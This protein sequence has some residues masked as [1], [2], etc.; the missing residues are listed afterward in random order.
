MMHGGWRREFGRRIISVAFLLYGCLRMLGFLLSSSMSYESLRVFWGFFSTRMHYLELFDF[1]LHSMIG[2][3]MVIWLLEAER[4][5]LSDAEE[6]VRQSQ[7]LEALG[8]LAGGI[9]HDFNNILT[10]ILGYSDLLMAR[11]GADDGAKD[12]QEIH[13]A[14]KR[15]SSLTNQL[16]AFS[17]KQVLALEVLDMNEVISGMDEMLRRLI[18]ESI[19]LE[20]RLDPTI[21]KVKADPSQL[22]QVVMKLA[23]NA[24]DAMPS[25]GT[26]TLTTANVVVDRGRQ[27]DSMFP[28]PGRYVKLAIE[29]T[30]VGMDEET[31]SR[32]FEPFFT[33]KK[34]GEGITV[35]SNKAKA[36]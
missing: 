33:T 25:G 31:K 29:D 15:G 3:G 1:F 13:R 4:K 5:K 34:L 30:G 11:L 24:R 18:P 26:L 14:A 28:E 36:T 17:H 23:L 19:R 32:I 27:R 16:L 2:L 20:L 6:R 35:S 22:T 7:K 12:A 9:A 10:V 8:R 21:D